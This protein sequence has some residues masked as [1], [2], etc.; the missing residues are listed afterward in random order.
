MSLLLPNDPYNVI[1]RAS[2]TILIPHSDLYQGSLDLLKPTCCTFFPSWWSLGLL[3]PSHLGRSQLQGR[4]GA[5]TSGMFPPPAA[6]A[7]SHTHMAELSYLLSH[8]P[9][10]SLLALTTSPTCSAPWERSSSRLTRNSLRKKGKPLGV[11]STCP[12]FRL[13]LLLPG[14]GQLGWTPAPTPI[15]EPSLVTRPN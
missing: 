12:Q 2:Y 1:K 11:T 8:F 9:S 14:A 10:R 5:G 13:W 4:L 15:S 6:V 3:N 7:T